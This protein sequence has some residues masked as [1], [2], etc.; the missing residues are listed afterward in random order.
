[1]ITISGNVT[2]QATGEDLP[3]ANIRIIDENK[4]TSSNMYGFYSIRVPAGDVNISASFI[5]FE[6][7]EVSFSA[8]NDTTINFR[9]I[10][11]GEQ[12][13]EVVVRT[14]RAQER[15]ES[16]QM[17]SVSLPIQQIREVPAIFGEVDIL[18]VAQ[19][20]PGVQSGSEGSTGFF[21]RGGGSDQNLI[22]LD[23]ATV[24]NASHLFGFFS[25]FNPETVRG[26]ELYKGGYPAKYGG[27]LSS[28]MDIQLKEGNNQKYG[29]SGGL[30]IISSR[31]MLEGPIVKDKS[32]FLIAGRRTY[33][34]IFTRAINQANTDNESFTPIPDYYFYDLNFKAN[35]RIN[36]NNRVFLSAYYGKDVFSFGSGIFNIDFDWGNFTTTARWNRVFNSR[37]FSNTTFT[38]SN[39][40]YKIEN[41]IDQF[42][43]SLGSRIQDFNFKTDFDYYISPNHKLNFGAFYTYHQFIPGRFSGSSEDDVVDFDNEENIDAHQFGLYVSDEFEPFEDLKVNVGLRLSA[44]YNEKFYW[45]LEPRVSA[46]YLLTE[47]LSLKA[48][49]TEMA[50][51]IHLVASS[52]ASLPTDIWYPSTS[53]IPPQKARQAA[54][55]VTKNLGW[56]SLSL[57]GEVYYKWLLNQV[58]F[59]DGAQLF[60]NPR[61]ED[62]FIFGDGYSYGFELFLEKQRGNTTG[63]IGYTWSISERTFEGVN[64]GNPF[65]PTYDRRHDISVVLSHKINRRWSVSGTW[66]YGSGSRTT[67]PV[68]R[69]LVFDVDGTTPS[70]V[71]EYTERNSFQLPAYHRMDLGVTYNFFPR[72]GEGDLN[73]GIY[74]VY[75]RRNPFF[76]FYD[77]NTNNDGDITG[78]QAKLVSLFP[79]IPSITFNFKI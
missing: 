78:Y 37:L 17:S 28:V 48:S 50:Q 20:T 74:N 22:L 51:Y 13:D 10:E 65:F 14:D 7:M 71:P 39:Y 62:E 61:L 55:G 75:N 9:L 56:Q 76:I 1:M 67:L 66:V 49:Y 27:R 64:N 18:K 53:V 63:W 40:N 6:T 26:L 24:Y 72:W 59:R 32:S 35:Y 23:E 60:L 4:G 54:V 19:L 41:S 33:F 57:S 46:R 31:L 29:A 43:F 34:D 30:G 38:F 70:I 52:G 16:T 45:N 25:V 77:E 58:D 3:G 21:V 2:E 15:V 73:F 69:Y 79:I 8:T 47:T 12:L 42:E 36:D 11:E 5:G 44:F 68:G